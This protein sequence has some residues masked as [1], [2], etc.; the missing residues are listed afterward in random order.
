MHPPSRD[1]AAASSLSS[2][3]FLSSFLSQPCT[4]ATAFLRGL[5]YFSPI[6]K[7]PSFLGSISFSIS[8][9]TA[10]TSLLEFYLLPHL[11]R[12]TTFLIAG[13]SAE[14]LGK[15]Q[16]LVSRPLCVTF[17]RAGLFLGPHHQLQTGFLQK[18]TQSGHICSLFP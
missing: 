16:Y 12:M 8:A 3:P 10:D 5:G 9:G 11:P 15:M 1:A 18:S 14:G 7:D 13:T 2:F 4:T 6:S 17:A